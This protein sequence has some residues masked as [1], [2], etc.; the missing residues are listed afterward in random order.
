V[1]TIIVRKRER[2]QDCHVGSVI[3]RRLLE[4][5]FATEPSPHYEAMALDQHAAP[6]DYGLVDIC[7][8]D[9]VR[10][11]A[12]RKNGGIAIAVS[13]TGI[14]MKP[15][16]IPKALEPFGQIDSKISRKHEG[17]GLGCLSP[18]IWPSCMAV[19]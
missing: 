13:D 5:T 7:T 19:R 4:M 8:G 12:Y 9:E 15:E 1:T 16:E 11:S 17:T 14:G 18:N 6:N 10:V 2:W 3:Y